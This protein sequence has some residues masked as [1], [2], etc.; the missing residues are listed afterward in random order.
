MTKRLAVWGSALFIWAGEAG[1]TPIAR[2]AMFRRWTA[3]WA[4]IPLTLGLGICYLWLAIRPIK[5]P[6]NAHP[7]D[8][9]I[10]DMVYE[11][12]PKEQRQKAHEH[13]EEVV[14]Q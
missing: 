2:W 10:I 14:K 6:K 11:G 8:E 7:S 12:R 13:H 5:P 1:G 9:E 3:L 4:T